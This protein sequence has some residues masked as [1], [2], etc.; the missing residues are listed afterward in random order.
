V[1]TSAIALDI[2]CN[3][4]LDGSVKVRP[5]FAVCTLLSVLFAVAA[6]A[7]NDHW[8]V[9]DVERGITSSRREQPGAGM[10]AFRGQ[11][12]LTGNV[13]QMLALLDDVSTT[14]RWACGVD[15]ARVLSRK[16]DRTDYIYV[17]SDVPWPVRDRDMVVRRDF[18]VVEPGKHFRMEL[19]CEPGRAPE[20]SG[21]VRVRSCESTF[22]LKKSDLTHTELDY[23][24]T[25]DP[26]GALPKWAG[27]WIAKHVPFRTLEAIERET[28]ATTE[29][30]RYEA[31]VR[32]WSAAM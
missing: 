3:T 19:H 24:M 31:A 22:E 12:A 13:L 10:P 17:Y 29:E 15:E 18:V 11:G 6:T 27:S 1:G 30:K 8:R 2:L 20:R 28:S 5:I 23:T 16:D 7:Q 9:I 25:L 4:G 26:A 32:R 14:P 21:V